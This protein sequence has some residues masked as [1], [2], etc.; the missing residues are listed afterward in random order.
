MDKAKSQSDMPDIDKLLRETLTRI[1]YGSI[2]IS[3]HDSRI[4][5]VQITEKMRFNMK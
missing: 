1:E 3:I 4:V 5:Q 2:E